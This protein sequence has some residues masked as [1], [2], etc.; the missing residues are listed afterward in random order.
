[1]RH[2]C[3]CRVRRERKV[4]SSRRLLW[5]EVYSQ[6]RAADGGCHRQTPCGYRASG[7]HS[8]A[9]AEPVA[10]SPCAALSAPAQ[11]CASRPPGS[12]GRQPADVRCLARGLTRGFASA[13][14]AGKTRGFASACLCY[15]FIVL[16]AIDA[17]LDTRLDGRLQALPCCLGPRC[18]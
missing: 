7:L 11:R 2:G 9:A 12:Q 8:F 16:R 5:P 10:E 6:R 3:R 14:Q 17:L 13:C 18:R 1:M 15:L 4:G